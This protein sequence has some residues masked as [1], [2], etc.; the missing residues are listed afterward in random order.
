L[1]PVGIGGGVR[2]AEKRLTKTDEAGPQARLTQPACSA[3]AV[4]QLP[5][6]QPPFDPVHDREVT[7]VVSSFLIVNVLFDLDVA[8]IV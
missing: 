3:E 7:P 8:T 5:P 2:V 4:Y 1:G 6:E